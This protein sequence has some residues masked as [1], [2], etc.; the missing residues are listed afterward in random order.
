MEPVKTIEVN[1]R[2]YTVKM[3]SPMEAFDY[4]HDYSVAKATGFGMKALGM[5]A[6]GQ[7]CDQMGRDLTGSNFD[8]HFNEHPKDMLALEF[9]AQ[10]A[11]IVPFAPKEKDM[12]KS[13]R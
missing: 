2:G 7:C 9:A 1:G 8:A 13:E 3:F 10:E 5:K 4:I 11:L 6:I 12:K